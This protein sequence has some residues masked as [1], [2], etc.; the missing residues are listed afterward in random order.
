MG[1]L[2]VIMAI[3]CGILKLKM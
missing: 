3:W 2:N 1:Q